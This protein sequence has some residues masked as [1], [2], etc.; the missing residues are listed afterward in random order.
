MDPE[1]K[2]DIDELLNG[3]ITWSGDNSDGYESAGYD[4]NSKMTWNHNPIWSLTSANVT[5]SVVSVSANDNDFNIVFD[6]FSDTSFDVKPMENEPA[7]YTSH[8]Q[9]EQHEKY[10]ALQKIWEDYLAMFALTKGEPPIVD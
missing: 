8:E 2:L 7:V 10:P 4:Q 1:D 3:N 5:A 6:D 9:R